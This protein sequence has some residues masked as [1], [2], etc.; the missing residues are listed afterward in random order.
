MLFVF[1]FNIFK[2]F[3]NQLLINIGNLRKLPDAYYA[4]CDIKF[5]KATEMGRA[6]EDNCTGY[7]NFS[8]LDDYSVMPKTSSQ[9]RKHMLQIHTNMVS[10]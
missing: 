2:Y 10:N 8:D 9:S 7:K 3:S 1:L 4:I 5:R 6:L